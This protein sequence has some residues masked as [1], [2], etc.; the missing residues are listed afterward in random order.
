L[1]VRQVE[2]ARS[3][4]LSQ[5]RFDSHGDGF[6]CGQRASCDGERGFFCVRGHLRTFE[7]DAGLGP[8]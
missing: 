8:E 2:G 7:S 5:L 6:V 4:S 3:M 1:Q